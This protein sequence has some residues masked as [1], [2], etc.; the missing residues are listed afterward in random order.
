MNTIMECGRPWRE[1]V[2]ETNSV[3]SDAPFR[4]ADARLSSCIPVPANRAVARALCGVAG[5]ADN[6]P[7]AVL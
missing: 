5:N 1:T 3:R 7:G 4:E 6:G 2:R